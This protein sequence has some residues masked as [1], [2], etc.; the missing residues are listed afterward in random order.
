MSDM[1]ADATKNSNAPKTIV[2][3]PGQI[4]VVDTFDLDEKIVVE[5]DVK[6]AAM[7]PRFGKEPRFVPNGYIWAPKLAPSE[8]LTSL[9]YD[10]IGRHTYKVQNAMVETGEW[11]WDLYNS[12]IIGE[13]TGMNIPHIMRAAERLLEGKSVVIAAPYAKD[14]KNYAHTVAN[15]IATYANR[16]LEDKSPAEE[17]E[18]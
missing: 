8:L 3:E 2:V 15:L 17:S 11:D 12:W 7:A 16:L 13:M 5:A 14:K 18:V 4:L 10:R 6:I 9:Y 1:T